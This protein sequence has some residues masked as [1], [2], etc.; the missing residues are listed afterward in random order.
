MCLIQ[1]TVFDRDGDPL[2]LQFCVGHSEPPTQATGRTAIVGRTGDRMTDKEW[3]DKRCAE[4]EIK[5]LADCVAALERR[6]R[7]AEGE[8]RAARNARDVALALAADPWRRPS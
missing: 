5:R 4:R 8:A 7:A 3:A 1:F 2:E 6:I